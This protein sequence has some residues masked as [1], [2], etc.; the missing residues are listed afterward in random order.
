M[1]NILNQKT[2]KEYLS[3]CNSNVHFKEPEATY[4]LWLNFKNIN[5]SHKEIKS[6]LLEDSKIALNDGRSF[7]SEGDSYF[8][9][10]CALPTS[11]LEKALSKIVTYF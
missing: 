2:T 1:M 4:L 6:K 10:N 7:G 5:L 8:R 11:E 9:L 3:K